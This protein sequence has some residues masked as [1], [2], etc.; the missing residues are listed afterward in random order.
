[1]R[2]FNTKTQVRTP[3]LIAIGLAAGILIGATMA[4]TRSTNNILLNSVIKFREVLTYL[5][6]SYVDEVDSETLVDTAIKNMLDKL[7]PHTIYIPK[8]D[9]ELTSGDLK[10]AF[11]GIGIEF[12]IIKDT[13]IVIAPLSGGPS[14]EVGLRSGDKIIRV[15]GEKVAGVGITIK[16]V[17]NRLRGEKGTEVVV[18]ILRK[19]EKELIDFTITRDE[20][21]QF[22]VDVGYM[23]DDETGYIK[24]SRFS[25]TTFE[26]FR[27]KLSDLN[28]KGMK[29][30]ILD[31]QGNPGGY[32]DRAVNIADEF[33]AGEG[34]IVSQEGRIKKYSAEY[35]AFREGAFEEGALIVLIDDGSA[36][37]SEIV[38]GALQDHDRALIVGRRSFG[39]GLVQ[40]PVTLSDGSELRVTI[41]R[42]Y[43][44]SGRCIQRPYNGSSDEY[45]HDRITRFENG[46]MFNA[47]S[48]HY[49]DTSK[50][51]TNKGRI[52]YGGGGIM[53]DYFV[54]LDTTMNSDYFSQLWYNNVIREY[55]LDYFNENRLDLEKYSIKEF[56]S[57]FQITDKM[58]SKLT[59]MGESSGIAFNEEEFIISKPLIKNR[60]KSFIARSLW[61]YDGWYPVAN[62]HNTALQEA[63]L[64]FDKADELVSSN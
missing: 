29:R 24:V 25:A 32:M 42:Y 34:L 51:Y 52:V 18:S 6:Q 41:S 43:T 54:A 13:I 20:I 23:I 31:L 48:I 49:S 59:S 16:G 61:N 19:K 64:L 11:E 46:E 1:M 5:D 36:S 45:H 58:L 50:Y 28:N 27:Q 53:P 3:M 14:E 60:V 2:K 47:D 8:D 55:T 37:G 10:G 35:S 17:V 7:D 56:V 39:K 63:M 21:P 26:E 9:V 40:M 4:D 15:D 44:P 38:A 33:I 12:N 62:E 22:S 57:S 30:L